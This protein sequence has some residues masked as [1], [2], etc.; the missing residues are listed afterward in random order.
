MANK[1]IKKSKLFNFPKISSCNWVKQLDRITIQPSLLS[2][3][4]SPTETFTPIPQPTLIKLYQLKVM[5]WLWTFLH[6]SFHGATGNC[7]EP[8]APLKGGRHS[9][10]TFANVY[11]STLIIQAMQIE[12]FCLP[13]A[14]LFCL[15]APFLG[16]VHRPM[17]NCTILCWINQVIF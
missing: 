2:F 4:D 8:V 12:K 3:Q 1:N 10:Q 15:H 16:C 14:V 13:V 5:G 9:M 17:H 11:K 6:E 7:W